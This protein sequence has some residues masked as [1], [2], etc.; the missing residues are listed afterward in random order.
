MTGIVSGS[1]EINDENILI[2]PNPV[3]PSYEGNLTISQLEGQSRVK[4]INVA[5]KVMCE[6]SSLSGTFTWNLRDYNN[7]KVPS[8]I[9]IIFITDENGKRKASGK[10]T[11]IR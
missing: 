1:K 7:K 6:G 11:V 10:V 3:K 4:I 5:G 8:G 2:Y 9:Y